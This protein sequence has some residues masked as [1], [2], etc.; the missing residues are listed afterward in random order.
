MKV[1]SEWFYNIMGKVMTGTGHLAGWVAVSGLFFGWL[2]GLGV[3]VYQ[4]GYW[5]IEARWVPIPISDVIPTPQYFY[6][7]KGLHKIIEWIFD[8]PLSVGLILVFGIAWVLFF[9][10]LSEE[11]QDSV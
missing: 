6:H 7:F 10:W 9:N 2:G 5:L 1:L 8:L 4:G 11:I 3:L